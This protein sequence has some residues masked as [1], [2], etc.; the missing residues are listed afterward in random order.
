M[1][2]RLGVD[3]R[4]AEQQ[5]RTPRAAQGL[6][7]DVGVAVFAQGENARAAKVAGADFVGDRT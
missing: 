7:K 1:P 6:G 4:K 3:V 2:L 5:S